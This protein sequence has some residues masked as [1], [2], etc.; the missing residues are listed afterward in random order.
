MH[1]IF[2]HFV[3]SMVRVMLV[4]SNTIDRDIFYMIALI[5]QTLEDHNHLSFH[6][7]VQGSSALV[8]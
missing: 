7:H 3:S 2:I 4:M 6:M 5:G 8:V 1:D